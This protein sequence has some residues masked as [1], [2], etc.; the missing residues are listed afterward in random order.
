MREKDRGKK[1]GASGTG[2]AKSVRNNDR[3]KKDNE[4]KGQKKRRL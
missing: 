4:G 3:G 1:Q 2:E